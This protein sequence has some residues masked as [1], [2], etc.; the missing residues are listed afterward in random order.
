VAITGYVVSVLLER[1]DSACTGDAAFL[2]RFAP[3]S[4]KAVLA[5]KRKTDRSRLAR[6]AKGKAVRWRR[7]RGET[8]LTRSESTRS[9]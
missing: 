1:S 4:D 2:V 8:L 7:R 6:A 5:S 9:C 3:F